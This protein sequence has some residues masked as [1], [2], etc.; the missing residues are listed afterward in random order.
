MNQTRQHHRSPLLDAREA[1]VG[2]TGAAYTAKAGDRVI[3][4]NRAG[5]VTVTLPSAEVRPGRQYSV[6]DESGSASSNNVTVATEASETIDG[7]STFTLSADYEAVFFLLGW[8]KLVRCPCRLRWR[9]RWGSDHPRR[10]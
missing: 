8:D 5:A 3:C 1:Y 4:V 2:V 9:R 10:R 7:S 6:K